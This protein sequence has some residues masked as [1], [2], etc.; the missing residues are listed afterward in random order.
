MKS[1]VIA[2]KPSVAQT[3]ARVLKSY[4]RNDGYIEGTE[5]IISWCIGHLVSVAP[6]EA[7][8]LKF[9]KW[10][11]SDLP[12][13]PDVWQYQVLSSTAKQFRILKKLMNS[14][15]VSEII[16][17]TDA[18]R[19]GELIFR[20]VYS[21]A[22][23]KKPFK[24]L[25]ISSLEESSIR[26]GFRNL[27]DGHEYDNLYYAALA[28][29]KADWLV[30]INATRLYSLKNNLKLNIGRVQTPVLNMLVNRED[31]I[32]GFQSKQ[33]FTV[34]LD[35]GC[36]KAESANIEQ[37]DEAEHISNKCSDKTAAVTNIS[38]EEKSTSAPKL[39]DLT[40]LQRDANR[41]F[42]YTAKQTLVYAQSLYES[43]FITYPRTDSRYIT[44]D[45]KASIPELME[46]V[47]A[48]TGV[49]CDN[50]I[51]IDKITN[52][53]KVSDHHALLPTKTLGKKDIAELPNGE[54]S[55]LTLICKRLLAAVAP[56]FLYKS[57]KVEVVCEGEIFAV[58]GKTVIDNGWKKY[59]TENNEEKDKKDES[60]LPELKMG[61][62]YNTKAEI[63]T[64]K[65]KPPKHF[66]EDTLLSAM[67]NAV[68]TENAERSGLGT[69]ATRADIIE[70]LVKNEFVT[71][72]GKQL[73]PS[74]KGRQLIAAVPASVKSADMT[75][76]WEARLSD[77]ANGKKTEREFVD[78]IVGFINNIMSE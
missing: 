67:E 20:F 55:I 9:R 4:Q 61:E 6:P 43:K 59:E 17:A 38:E 68:K 48:K 70:K 18:G 34:E 27:H 66:T 16:C 24:R 63:K 36:F 45:V 51:D 35:C 64:H 3:I 21:E 40:S 54:R 28:R 69:P 72:K 25:W 26:D 8:D 53:N 2:E 75:A 31:E 39:Y 32:A 60:M 5:Y 78:D 57:V 12:I 50:N 14:R 42:G 15:D 62:T 73:L 71:R 10:N 47:T 13:V 46:I 7:Y 65:T 19:E 23:C 37:R 49:E 58:T 1:L 52:N 76:E 41:I 11:M 22:G 29:A 33:Y 77:I 44:E 74:E 30:G 56:A